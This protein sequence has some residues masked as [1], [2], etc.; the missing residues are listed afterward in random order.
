MEFLSN[1]LD[2]VL[3]VILL[4]AK[5]L[6][7]IAPKTETEVDDKIVSAVNWGLKHARG[8]FEIVEDLKAVGILKNAK[9]D[10]FREELQKQ[11]RKVYGKEL[12][13]EALAAAEN[14]AAGLAAE[15]HNIK[16]LA[17]SVAIAPDPQSAPAAQG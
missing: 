4:A 2:T 9:T 15:D 5:L 12:P 17:G 13:G 6:E 3:L 10:A 8:A 7:Y 11:Y 16:R 1:N 14:V